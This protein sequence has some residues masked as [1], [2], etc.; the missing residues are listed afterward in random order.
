[1]LAFRC[2]FEAFLA[3]RLVQLSP[4]VLSTVYTGNEEAA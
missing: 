2:E 1:M 4:A 3:R